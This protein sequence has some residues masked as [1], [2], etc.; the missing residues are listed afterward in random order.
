MTNHTGV[1]LVE[2]DIKLSREIEQC[3]IYDEDEIRQCCD[4]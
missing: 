1:I 4:Q 2:Y 3:V